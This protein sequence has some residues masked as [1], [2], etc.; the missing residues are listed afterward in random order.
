MP[1]RKQPWGK[2]AKQALADLVA[3]EWVEAGHRPLRPHGWSSP[4][5][6]H[7]GEPRPGRCRQRSG[8]SP[9]RGGG[10]GVAG[11]DVPSSRLP[12]AG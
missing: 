5:Q 10:I 4:G 12:G 7:R 6:R 3:G 11:I 1:E 2:K 9:G 8:C